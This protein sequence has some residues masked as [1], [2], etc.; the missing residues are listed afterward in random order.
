MTDFGSPA[1]L[2]ILPP[3][4]RD[5][6]CSLGERRTFQDGELVH[7]H[8]DGD[9]GMGIVH[10]GSIKLVK[11][12]KDGREVF[13]AHIN[14]GQ[15]YGDNVV[16][17]RPARTHRA[18]AVGDTV[19]GHYYPDAMAKMLERP[20]I[21]RALYEIA[22]Y[23]LLFA[24]DLLDDIRTHA[25]E[26]RLAKLLWT[27]RSAAGGRDRLECV[28]EDLANLMGVSTVTLAKALGA[29]KRQSLVT[30]G[31]RQVTITDPE[32][33]AAWLKEHGPG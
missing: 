21:V 18:I 10:S 30:T 7:Q 6:L 32:L 33:F 26:L 20:P 1:L 24:I 16:N 12:S 31:Y 28:Q 8:G 22:S 4:E 14:P 19:I 15:H 27:M 9:T 2:H 17:R 3:E 5:Y 11:S 25:P 29:L 23:R 13:L